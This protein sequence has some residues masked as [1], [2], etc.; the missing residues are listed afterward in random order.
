MRL[1]RWMGDGCDGCD[2]CDPTRTALPLC[3]TSHRPHAT[4]RC[5]PPPLAHG[6]RVC[7]RRC[8]WRRVRQRWRTLAPCG[9]CLAASTRKRHPRER[10]VVARIAELSPPLLAQRPRH[11]VR[12]CCTK[13]AA[14]KPAM[15][16]FDVLQ[17][18]VVRPFMVHSR[19]N[20]AQKGRPVFQRRPHVMTRTAPH[21]MPDSCPPPAVN[22]GQIIR[23]HSKAGWCVPCRVRAAILPLW[24]GGSVI[25]WLPN[26]TRA[27][28]RV[29]PFRSPLVVVW[30]G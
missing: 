10:K 29:R 11:F 18:F 3:K 30:R 2:G 9:S 8:C 14:W 15:C 12:T 26:T 7:R 4:C 17:P 21:L 16:R 25:V 20:C 28:N 24:M 6:A 22:D 19:R 27:A 1:T 5:D 13:P 23:F